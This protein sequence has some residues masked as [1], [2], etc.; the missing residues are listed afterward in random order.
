MIFKT[1]FFGCKNKNFAFWCSFVLFCLFSGITKSLANAACARLSDAWADSTLKSYTPMFRLYI[2]FMIHTA[3]VL[4]QVK[5][6][7]ILAFLEF[8]KFNG[9]KA[10]QMQNYLSAI[11]SFSIKVALPTAH[12]LDQ[13]IPMYIKAV[14]KTAPFVVKLNNVIDIPLLTDLVAA[15][16]KTHLGS[17]FKAAYLLGF[18]GF[19]RLSNLVP[20]SMSTYSYLK[21]IAKG[22]VF[23][24]PSEAIVLIK[25]S[26]TMRNNDQA[27]LLKLPVLN[28]HLCPAQALKACLKLVPG[29]SNFPLF[30]FKMFK[31]WV[32]LTDSRVR[33]HLRE[34]LILCGKQ[35]N[36][37]SCL[38]TFR[39]HL[40]L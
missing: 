37:I 36:F 16:Q 20:H 23:F 7:N 15:C 21:H 10:P 40:R 29:A 14:Q 5:S 2:A 38:Q 12:L 1:L 6:E 30:Q 8:L 4:H 26:K 11:R 19:L 25:W 34:I 3:T 27:K 31:N 22:D 39:C 18:F 28:N 24:T 13:R 35:P 17:I 9:V 32:P 33:A